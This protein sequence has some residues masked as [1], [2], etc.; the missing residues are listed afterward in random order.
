M[1]CLISYYSVPYSNVAVWTYV[2]G[3]HYFN[4]LFWVCMYRSVPLI[5]PPIFE[6]GVL[7]GHYWIMC[8]QYLVYY[9][10]MHTCPTTLMNIQLCACSEVHYIRIMHNN[11]LVTVH[12]VTLWYYCVLTIALVA[13][14]PL[15]LCSTFLTYL[16]NC[17]CVA[18]LVALWRSLCCSGEWKTLAS[19]LHAWFSFWFEGVY[20]FFTMYGKH[21]TDTHS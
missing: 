18:R 17:T 5:R 13:L 3:N 12:G 6:G 16:S 2:L 10:N 15:P 8:I 1:S 9:C 7:A 19:I 21:S 4:S 11:S 14:L 20:C